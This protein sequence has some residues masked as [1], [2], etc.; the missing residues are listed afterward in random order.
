MRKISAGLLMY[1][2]RNHAIEVLLAHPGGPFWKN[3]DEGAW[4]IPKGGVNEN[5][6]LIDAA[7]REFR[8]ETGLEPGEKLVPLPPIRQKSGK[9]VHAWC[10]EGD[11]DP[12]ACRSINY[13]ME[14]P[15]KSGK[16]A[17]F[18]EIDRA[19]FFDLATA[20]KKILPAQRVFLNAL[21]TLVAN[22]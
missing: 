1:R 2:R 7:R 18:P 8:E 21:A 3:R 4:T 9:I 14:W 22:I 13:S 12:T 6:E 5:E 16:Q 11:C 15:L 10:F 20:A 17:E 19:E